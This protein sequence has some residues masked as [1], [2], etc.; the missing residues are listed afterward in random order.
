MFFIWRITKFLFVGK[1]KMGEIL[2]PQIQVHIGWFLFLLFD[3]E[4]GCIQT[5]L[6][7]P[8]AR[9]GMKLLF[10][11]ALKPREVAARK[12]SKTFHRYIVAVMAVHKSFQ[13]YLTRFIKIKQHIFKGR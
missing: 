11:I 9:T 8:S 4:T 6:Q 1:G 3:Q 12:K 13:I 7:Q 5:L 2:K 10:K